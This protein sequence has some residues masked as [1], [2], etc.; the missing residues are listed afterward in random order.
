[1]INR[2]QNLQSLSPGNIVL[3]FCVMTFFMSIS[4]VGSVESRAD[5]LP[6]SCGLTAKQFEKK[7]K[8]YVG[9]PYRSGGTSEKGMDCSGF[10]RTLYD[11]LFSIELPHSSIEQYQSSD[12]QKIS[13]RRMQPGDL[14]FFAD[15]KKKRI[16][17]VGVYLSNGKFIHASSSLG[18]TVS[19]LSESYWKKRFVGSKRHQDLGTSSTPKQMKFESSVEIPVH[20]R[21]TITGS[22]QHEFR[23]NSA[24]F[25]QDESDTFNNSLYDD[26]EIDNRYFSFYQIGYDHWINNGLTV[27]FST[28]REIFDVSTAWPGLDLYSRNAG[29]GQDLLSADTALRNGF[30]VATDIHPSNWLSIT[31]FITFFDNYSGVQEDW[32][33]PKRTFGLNSL[34][35]PGH[36]RW[37]LAM[38]LQYSDQQDLV[39]TTN[40]DNMISSLDMSIKLGLHLTENLQLSLMGKHDIRMAAYDNADDSSSA[41]LSSNDVLLTFDLTY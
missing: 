39:N 35:T 4:W 24:A 15:K 17:H 18:I 40:V 12:L 9:I 1:M 8:E 30:Q 20:R 25:L 31:P 38:L 28:F 19:K 2:R 16:N 23:S 22:A 10:A 29:Y 6:S 27:N 36:G 26:P 7:A 3:F 13:K 11:K 37:S 14:I 34:V 41:Q 21:G 33:V 5:S 32:D